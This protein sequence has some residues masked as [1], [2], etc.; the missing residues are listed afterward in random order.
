MAIRRIDQG[1]LVRYDITGTRDEVTRMC[2]D[3][4]SLYPTARY[5]TRVTAWR[6]GLGDYRHVVV[7]RVDVRPSKEGGTFN[8]R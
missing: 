8:Y 6:K 7:Q 1:R 4:E 3:L 2:E 5:A